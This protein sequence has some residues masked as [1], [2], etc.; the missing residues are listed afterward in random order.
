LNVRELLG[1]GYPVVLSFQL[2]FGLLQ[3]LDYFNVKYHPMIHRNTAASYFDLGFSLVL[4]MVTIM[5]F[6]AAYNVLSGQFAGLLASAPLFYCIANME[7]GVS[8]ASIFMCLVGVIFMKDRGWFTRAMLWVL[9]FFSSLGVIHWGILKP[10]GVSSPLV[11]IATLMYNVHHV[12]RRLFPVLV[13]PFLFFWLLKPVIGLKL[14]F[15]EIRINERKLDSFSLLLLV[16]SLF[17]SVYAAIYPYF[18]T[19][20][21]ND[22]DFGVD[23]PDHIQWLNMIE[24]MEG[25]LASGVG[26][27][28]LFF[29]LVFL[30]FRWLTGF[31]TYT[32]IRFLPV[33]LNPLFVLASY[34]FS[35]EYF[36]NSRVAAWCAF[37]SSTGMTVTVGLYAFF[38]SNLLALCIVLFSLG[39]LFRAVSEGSLRLLG[40]ASLTGS[41]LVFTHPWT[42]DQ[43]LAGLLLFLGIALYRKGPQYVNIARYIGG[44]LG[45]VGLAEAVKIV[46]LGSYGGAAVTSTAVSGLVNFDEIWSSLFFCFPFIY[47]GFISNIILLVLATVGLYLLKL[48]DVPKRYLWVLVLLSSLVYFISF[49]TNK[50]R[51]LYNIPFGFFGSMALY[52]V[53]ERRDF[54]STIFIV[55]YSLFYF[56][57]SVGSLVW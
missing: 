7:L 24:N 32:A 21:P 10:L 3:L 22:V 4:P 2:I 1:R 54:S 5:V 49:E 26:A 17:I 43:Y 15:P 30:G 13:L 52:F 31:D 33:L 40:L 8:M 36:R 35:W 23:L 14:R 29:F 19:V 44:Y 50:S 16:F 37:L 55:I 6:W 27:A 11:D 28:R 9:T 57:V 18:P 41:L 47:G 38:L 12:L 25:G 46:V 42:M 56:L 34:Y 53:Y 39:L 20:N 48:D 51:I 45:V